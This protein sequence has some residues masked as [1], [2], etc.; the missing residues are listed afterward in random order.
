MPHGDSHHK[1]GPDS[2]EHDAGEEKS[3]TSFID[4]TKLMCLNE[5]EPDSMKNIVRPFEDRLKTDLPVLVSDVDEQLLMYVPFVSPVK[6]TSICII[7]PGDD[8]NPAQMKAFINREGLD[9][10]NV[11]QMKSVQEWDLIRQNDGT[12]VYPTHRTKFMNVSNLWLFIPKNF[13]AEKTS[14]MYLGIKGEFTRHKREAV[15]TVY[16][17]QAT[18]K[19]EGLESEDKV[20]GHIH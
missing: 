7:G 18:K 10:S 12:V 8:E 2:H 20:H 14:V 1:H 5:K 15:H 16:E 19:F 13:G 4:T 9:F 17:A 6:M 11:E 3:L